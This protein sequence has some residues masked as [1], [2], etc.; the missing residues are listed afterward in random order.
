MTGIGAVI[1]KDTKE[2]S[3]M[4]GNPAATMEEYKKWS[5]IK[6]KLG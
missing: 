5:D 4:I 6:K 1:L 3:V 2:N